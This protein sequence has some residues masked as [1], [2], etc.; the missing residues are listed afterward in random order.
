MVETL[1][2]P[3]EDDSGLEAASSVLHDAVF[4]KEGIHYDSGRK[5]F[6]L[7]LWREI[8]ESKRQTRFCLVFSKDT[9]S[10]CRLHSDLV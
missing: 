9:V 2:L 4:Q 1:S 8:L 5:R 3:M 7:H 6:V 10:A